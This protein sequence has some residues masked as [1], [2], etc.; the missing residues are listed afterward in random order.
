[1]PNRVQRQGRQAWLP[2]DVFV[3]RQPRVLLQVLQER[4]FARA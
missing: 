1:M 3:V 4:R 2:K